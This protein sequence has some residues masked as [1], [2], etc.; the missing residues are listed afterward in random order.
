MAIS[1]WLIDTVFDS[2]SIDNELSKCLS[3]QGIKDCPFS[4]SVQRFF[5]Q[6]KN[7]DS[8]GVTAVKLL[9][10]IQGF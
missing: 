8:Y 5:P 3:S 1:K 10:T 9:S 7:K 4:H 2:V 6:P